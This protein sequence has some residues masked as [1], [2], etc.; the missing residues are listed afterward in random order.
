VH[1]EEFVEGILEWFCRIGIPC[2]ALIVHLDGCAAE[3]AVYEKP[4]V[5][6]PS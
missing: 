3:V 2:K 4:L 1:D 6:P 5:G